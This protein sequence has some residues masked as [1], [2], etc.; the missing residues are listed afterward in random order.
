MADG[1]C[2]AIDA[3]DALGEVNW[4]GKAIYV[5]VFVCASGVYALYV[6]WVIVPV[7]SLS[8]PSRRSKTHTRASWTR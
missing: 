5:V 2:D 6:F 8:C 4:E 7:K 1:S 3:N